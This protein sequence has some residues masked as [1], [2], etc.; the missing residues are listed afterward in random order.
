MLTFVPAGGRWKR[1]LAIGALAGFVSAVAALCRAPSSS[2]PRP[3]VAQDAV[4]APGPAP[5]PSATTP[6]PAEPPA[7]IPVLAT[8]P[9]LETVC[10]G[11]ARCEGRDDLDGDGAADCWR[12]DG[13]PDAGDA[14]RLAVQRACTGAALRFAR[15]DAPL[16]Q[17]PDAARDPRL[18]DGVLALAVGAARRCVTAEAGCPAVDDWL[19]LRLDMLARRGPDGPRRGPQGYAPRWQP[20]APTSTAAQSVVVPAAIAA[21]LLA[22]ERRAALSGPPG[23]RPVPRAAL[24]RGPRLYAAVPP[25]PMTRRASCARF[26]VW[27]SR[28]AI[29]VEEIAGGRW[30]WIHDAAG[31]GAG[32]GEVERVACLGD[33]VVAEL[34]DDDLA[35]RWQVVID[36]DR[37]RWR[38]LDLELDQWRVDEAAGALVGADTEGAPQRFPLAALR[39]LLH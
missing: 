32:D 11:A 5:V 23:S 2:P 21:A 26:A 29:A 22:D 14:G 27:A 1:S 19:A 33:L 3:A 36:P 15:D 39:D 18:L 20:A 17:L 13:D 35:I 8:R 10:A 38:I 24:P 4:S 31:A 28:R 37:G 34:H 16:W 9:H 25:G 12:W 7:T 30:S 6:P